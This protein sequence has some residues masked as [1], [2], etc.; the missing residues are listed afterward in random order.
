MGQVPSAQRTRRRAN[1]KSKR[2]DQHPGIA[3]ILR[4]RSGC[5][6]SLRSARM[7]DR[8]DVRDTNLAEPGRR[9]IDWANQEMPVLDHIRQRFAKERPLAGTRVAACLHVT[10]E[11][12]NLMRTLQPGGG[13]GVFC[14]SNPLS[15]PDGA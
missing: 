15:P 9:R 10:A 6:V 7:S 12:A 14:A 13:G 2:A 5:L 3:G 4:L 8:Y 1:A 11:T